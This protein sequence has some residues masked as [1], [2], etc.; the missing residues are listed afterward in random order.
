[1]LKKNLYSGIFVL[2]VQL[3]TGEQMARNPKKN[4]DL[5]NE[6][7][8]EELEGVLDPIDDSDLEEEEDSTREISF[9][10]SHR[11]SVDWEDLDN[12]DDY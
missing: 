11:R 1:M 7:E 6:E 9:D 2:N 3:H 12:D 10:D 8:H 4:K 5:D